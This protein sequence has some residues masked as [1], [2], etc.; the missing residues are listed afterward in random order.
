MISKR[1]LRLL[2]KHVQA[3]DS[4]LLYTYMCQTVARRNKN[5]NM[6]SKKCIKPSCFQTGKVVD[7]PV[8]QLLLVP[9]LG[10]GVVMPIARWEC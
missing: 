5:N 3:Y 7:R 1:S 8:A 9:M 4:A 2:L 6:F 10:V